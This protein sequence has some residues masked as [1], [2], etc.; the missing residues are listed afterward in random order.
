MRIILASILWHFDLR[1][2]APG[3]DWTDQK[4]YIAWE[5]HPLPVFLTAAHHT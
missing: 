4:T 2:A 1:L 3:F 5:K